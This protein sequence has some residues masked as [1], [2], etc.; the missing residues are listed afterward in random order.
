[1]STSPSTAPLMRTPKTPEAVQGVS[2]RTINLVIG[3]IA[4]L[5]GPALMLIGHLSRDMVISDPQLIAN[6][7]S[8]YYHH[9]SITRDLFVGLLSCIG[10]LTLCYRG[11]NPN[12][13]WVD[14]LIGGSGCAAAMLVANVPCCGHRLDWIHNGAAAFFIVL[15]A[16]M[17]MTRFTEMSGDD[18]EKQH[19]NWK[20][21]R[22]R[23]Y[24]L[25][26]WGMLLS[27]L[28][29]LLHMLAPDLVGERA[30]ML[31][32]LGALTCFGL[33]W[34]AKSRFIFG[35]RIEALGAFHRT[36]ARE[37]ILLDVLRLGRSSQQTHVAK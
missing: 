15:L 5:I 32:E 11:W 16:V 37:G 21:I 22:N 14:R 20:R 6:S 27:L 34:L 35:Y 24:R 25:L 9:N 31:T 4:L 10:F 28:P 18:D 30:V 8:A 1:M 2:S 33:G 23:I 29:A 26:G 19:S 3:G 13:V 36:Q 17:L 12:I 7:I